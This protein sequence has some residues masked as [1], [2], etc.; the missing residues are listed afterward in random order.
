MDLHTAFMLSSLPVS[1]CI[2]NRISLTSYWR[3]PP[4]LVVSVRE[5]SVPVVVPL[6]L[7]P[8]FK[9]APLFI[10]VSVPVPVPVVVVPGLTVVFVVVV[11]DES[12]VL[13][14]VPVLEQ[15]KNHKANPPKKSTRL[16]VNV[17]IKYDD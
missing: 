5:V 15:L 3:L 13:L 6:V 14:S 1:A 16:I 12:L 9:L 4:R 7:P 17:F 10:P 11:V 2:L 8:V